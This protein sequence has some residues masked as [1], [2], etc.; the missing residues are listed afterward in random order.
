M[1][2]KC[3]FA[4]IAAGS[5]VSLGNAAI[6][7]VG[8]QVTQIAQPLDARFNV[9]TNPNTAYC[10]NEIQNFALD[11]SVAIDAFAPGTYN[12]L[13]DLISASLTAGTVV[14]SHYIHFDVAPQTSASIQ[15]RV[16]FD[17]QILGVIV[18]NEAGA[19]HL[20]DSDFLGAPTLF[21]QGNN[22]RGLEFG[23]DA[24][25][26]TISGDTIEF[27]LSITQ[28]GDFIRV[29]T[30]PGPGSLALAGFGL[31]GLSRRRR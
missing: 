31:L 6:V 20:D 23:S 1:H 15:G 13:G 14:N 12:Q 26:L 3:A 29:L 5:V 2:W 28:P 22:N 10:W 8:G 18:L 7:A 16:R 27:D 9:L 11:R 4:A 21:T 19:R 24:F 30:V 17:G 25:R